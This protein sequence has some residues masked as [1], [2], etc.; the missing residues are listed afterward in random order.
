MNQPTCAFCGGQP[1]LG[2]MIPEHVFPRYLRDELNPEP[3]PMVFIEHFEDPLS[4]DILHESEPLEDGAYG[5]TVPDVC[6]DCNKKLLNEKV[7]NPI[8]DVL[9][10]MARGHPVDLSSEEV[11]QLATWAAKT[12]M[13]RELMIKGRSAIPDLHYRILHDYVVPPPNTMI[14]FGAAED[15]PE[16]WNRHRTFRRSDGSGR[17]HFTTIVVGRLWIVVAGFSTREMFAYDWTRVDAICTSFYLEG[18][19]A[20]IWPPEQHEMTIDQETGRP[21][22]HLDQR[23]F[24]PGP[25]VS[26]ATYRRVSLGPQFPWVNELVQAEVAGQGDTDS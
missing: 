8:A 26:V 1:G 16:S 9:L 22:F 5:V 20:Q 19:L 2:A 15:T 18:A 24:P 13:T 6:G 7:E 3:A 25:E 10:R 21:T 4:G 17:G 14:Y 12:A 23:S 11:L